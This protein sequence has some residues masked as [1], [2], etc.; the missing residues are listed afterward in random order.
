M[1]PGADSQPQ[2]Q[3]PGTHQKPQAAGW[4]AGSVARDV[5]SKTAHAAN[6][7]SEKA[8]PAAERLS[9]CN[10]NKR[11]KATSSE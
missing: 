9:A 6:R 3:A 5:P 4:Q 11:D 1:R 7:K 2:Q 8:P 10:T